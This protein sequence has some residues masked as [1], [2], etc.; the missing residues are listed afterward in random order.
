VVAALLERCGRVLADELSAAGVASRTLR[1]ARGLLPAEAGI[2]R[3]RG[4]RVA[5]RQSRIATICRVRSALTARHRPAPRET[6]RST[7]RAPTICIG[8]VTLMQGGSGPIWRC[9]VHI[10]VTRRIENARLKAV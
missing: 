4:A 8:L 7:G 6:T 3:P 1:R 2:A 5:Q 9:V 10:S